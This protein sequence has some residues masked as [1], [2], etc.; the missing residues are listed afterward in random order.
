V[1]LHNG[2]PQGLASRTLICRSRALVS[3]APFICFEKIRLANRALVEDARIVRARGPRLA[4]KGFRTLISLLALIDQE[5]Q[6]WDITV[7]FLGDA[8]GRRQP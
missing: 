1:A 4:S 8:S 6:A 3:P 7:V 2:Q 5:G